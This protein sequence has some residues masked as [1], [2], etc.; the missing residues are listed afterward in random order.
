[1]QRLGLPLERVS[2]GKAWIERGEEG[3]DWVAVLASFTGPDYS[4]LLANGH[5]IYGPAVVEESAA[6]GFL[7]RRRRERPVF[8]LS[9]QD[10]VAWIT[11]F[12]VPLPL[13]ILPID[14]LNKGAPAQSREAVTRMVDQ[15]HWMGGSVR[16]DF[17]PSCTHLIAN[18]TQSDKYRVSCTCLRVHAIQGR[19]E[20]RAL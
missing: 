19:G 9:M 14:P 13:L 7:V 15:I 10:V 8:C 17:S 3:K 11:G 1:M 5:R 4:Y 18:T 12:T 16:K 2:S 20:E 6:Q